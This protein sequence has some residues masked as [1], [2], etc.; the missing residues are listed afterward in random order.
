[1]R[2]LRIFASPRLGTGVASNLIALLMGAMPLPALADAPCLY[3]GADE[4][5]RVINR[6][7][8]ITTPFPM[9]L[10][11]ND[12]SRLRVATGT[13]TVY[14]IRPDGTQM[15]KA[16]VSKGPLLLAPSGVPQAGTDTLG[17]LKQIVVV[18][19]GV[20]RTK[21]GSSR[22]TEGDYLIASLP[23]GKLAAPANDLVLVLGPVPD[24]GLGRFELYVNGKLAHRQSGPAATIQMPKSALKAGS[25]VRWKL[26]YAGG[27]YEGAFTVEAADAV[28]KLLQSQPRDE[29]TG[30]DPLMERLDPA[31]ALISAGYAWDARELIRQALTPVP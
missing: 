16:Q 7:G 31:F 23:K 28:T 5:T 17:I 27:G 10:S 21:T 11:N 24:Q 19:E 12:C 30:Q 8:E 25:S 4:D 6:S 22:S 18:L 13:A 14:V 9:V 1:M 26:E 29:R 2:T 20:N 3:R 15:T